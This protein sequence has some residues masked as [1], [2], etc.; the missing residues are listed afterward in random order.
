MQGWVP[1][2]SHG[3]KDSGKEGQKGTENKAFYENE[4][5]STEEKCTEIQL[6]EQLKFI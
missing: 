5:N 4:L 3:L 6:E 2:W 1:G